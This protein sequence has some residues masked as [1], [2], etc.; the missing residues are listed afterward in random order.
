MIAFTFAIPVRIGTSIAIA[1]LI[2]IIL[3]QNYSLEL[4]A[5]QLKLT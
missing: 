1:K 3:L 4:L 2:K 5:R